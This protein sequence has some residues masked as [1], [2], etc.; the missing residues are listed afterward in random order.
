MNTVAKQ[1]EVKKGFNLFVWPTKLPSQ[2]SIAFPKCTATTI[3][4]WFMTSQ[5]VSL[6]QAIQQL[7]W[8]QPAGSSDGLS[9]GHS[10]AAV[11]WCLEQ[12]CHPH[13]SR[14]WCWLVGGHRVSRRSAMLSFWQPERAGVEAPRLPAFWTWNTH[15][16]L[17]HP[18][19]QSKTYYQ[20][21]SKGFGKQIPPLE[22]RSC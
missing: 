19:G 20:H 1:F 12:D 16:T 11:I 10:W 7:G 9:W 5:V 6:G 4:F 22:V 21:R 17:P 2:L 18:T 13:M 15:I 8:V 14:G 3:L